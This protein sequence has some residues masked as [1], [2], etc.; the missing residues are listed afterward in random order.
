MAA[1]VPHPAD[2]GAA[3]CGLCAE[4]RR[5]RDLTP[6]REYGAAL[7]FSESFQRVIL[8]CPECAPR[9]STCPACGGRFLIDEHGSR[10]TK[11]ER[12][13]C[14][15]EAGHLTCPACD[16]GG[17]WGYLEWEEDDGDDELA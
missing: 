8:V 6:A 5:A 4:P 7:P 11:Y 14:E 15:G 10:D 13:A 12:A 1:A 3:P 2:T 17:D 9:A 16:P